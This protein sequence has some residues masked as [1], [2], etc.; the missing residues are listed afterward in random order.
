MASTLS[1]ENISMCE[2]FQIFKLVN[3]TAV[4]L[5]GQTFSGHI[6]II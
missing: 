5:T 2:M 1:H 4:L 3:I 6:L